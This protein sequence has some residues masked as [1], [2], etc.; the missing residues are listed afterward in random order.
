MVQITFTIDDA[1]I[2]RVKNALVGFYPIPII[3]DPENPMGQIPQFTEN[4]WAK[5]C[6]RRWIIKQVAQWEQ[7][8][9]QKTI[10]YNEEDGLIN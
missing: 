10:T 2:D 8:Q 7:L 4:Q 3:Q 6:V 9:A 1:K 5:E